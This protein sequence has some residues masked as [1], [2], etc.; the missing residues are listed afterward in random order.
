MEVL[1]K[2]NKCII[3]DDYN[4]ADLGHNPSPFFEDVELARA[5][6]HCNSAFVVPARLLRIVNKKKLNRTK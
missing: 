5:C 3:C 6:D 2:L 4:I 1:V